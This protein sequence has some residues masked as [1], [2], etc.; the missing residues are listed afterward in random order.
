MADLP[1]PR[2]LPEFQKLFP[3][4]RACASY[5]ERARWSK[6]FA[7]PSCNESGEPFRFAKRPGVLRCRACRKDTSLTAGTVMERTH[8][9]LSTWFWAAYLVSTQTPGLS[10]VQF[11]RQLGL[12]RYETAFQILH[13]LRAGM[14]RQNVDR[15]GGEACV[16]EMDETLVG[17]ETRGEGSGRHHMIYVVGA[18]EVK[19]RENAPQTAREMRRQ[20]TYAGRLRL[21]VIPDRQGSTLREFTR[22]TIAQR[23][24]VRTDGWAGYDQISHECGV[25]H[26][27]VVEGGDPTIAERQLPLVHL[28]FS[29]LKA[30]LLGTHHSVS[31]KHLQAYLNEFVFRFNRRFYPF[32]GFR[33]L[34]GLG[35]VAESATYD[36]LYSGSWVHPVAR[37]PWELTG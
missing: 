35:A 4:D 26:H 31:D 8:T 2:S 19:Q 16:V 13:K 14:V 32:N 36:D 33:S 28:V 9:P 18:V 21:R 25:E 24:L 37:A 30:W 23:T 29:N 20:G 27:P 34:L 10:A 7:C 11:Q 3:D 17:G 12:S 1:F 22:D 6:A 15:I 5:L